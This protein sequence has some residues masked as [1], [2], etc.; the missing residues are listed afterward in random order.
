MHAPTCVCVV[1]A[2]IVAVVVVVTARLQHDLLQVE[3]QI[4]DLEGSYLEETRETGN[5]FTGWDEYLGL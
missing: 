5:I 3:K 2:G 1:A 4:Y